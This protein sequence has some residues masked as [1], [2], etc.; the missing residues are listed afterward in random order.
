M[1]LFLCTHAWMPACLF[2]EDLEYPN[3]KQSSGESLIEAGLV[4]NQ[5]FLKA[6]KTVD[7][8][9]KENVHIRLPYL[10]NLESQG[11]NL[12]YTQEKFFKISPT[13]LF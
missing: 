13:F 5:A 4:G 7:L 1:C 10:V 9:H 11:F 6:L 3:A 2:Q 12:N 8:M